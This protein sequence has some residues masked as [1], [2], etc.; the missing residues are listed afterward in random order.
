MFPQMSKQV[1]E[2][3]KQQIEQLRGAL[4]VQT[5][6]YDITRRKIEAMNDLKK[7]Q[8]KLYTELAL[9]EKRRNNPLIE[10]A[11]VEVRRATASQFT[12]DIEQV[13]L[14]HAMEGRN[15]DAIREQLDKLENPSQLLTAHLRMKPGSLS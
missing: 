1:E 8:W 15:L 7:A 12:C 3:R 10:E 9:F 6:A 11:Y 14:H 2:M 13:E 5:T 4:D